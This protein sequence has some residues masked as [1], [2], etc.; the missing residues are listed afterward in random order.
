MNY[1]QDRLDRR[2]L[3]LSVLQ[4]HRDDDTN[5]PSRSTHHDTGN[6]TTSVVDHTKYGQ[7]CMML[8]WNLHALYHYGRAWYEEP[9][10]CYKLGDYVQM[11]EMYGYPEIALLTIFLYRTLTTTIPSSKPKTSQNHNSTSKNNNDDDDDDDDN[12]NTIRTLLVPP[13]LLDDT[14]DIRSPPHVVD[15]GD[16]QIPI[17]G[18]TTTGNHYEL[19]SA[20]EMMGYHCGCQDRLCGQ[21]PTNHSSQIF[22]CWI[23]MP[24]TAMK[25]IIAQL[26]S[27]SQQT[28]VLQYQYQQ[29]DTHVLQQPSTSL[30]PPTSHEML[31]DWTDSL[32]T[33]MT[34]FVAASKRRIPTL[35]QFWDSDVMSTS[36]QNAAAI[37]T[38]PQYRTLV[39][40]VQ[41]LCI[42]L[43]YLV[44][45][46]LAME[47]T[48]HL[49]Y[50][51]QQLQ[52]FVNQDM[53]EQIR[54]TKKEWD[55]LSIQYKSH[56]AYYVFIEALV[57]GERIKVAR[58]RQMVYQHIALWDR[59]W[60]MNPIRI[61]EN[62]STT[63]VDPNK[64]DDNA[65]TTQIDSTSA[66]TNKENHID[67]VNDFIYKLQSLVDEIYINDFHNYDRSETQTCLPSPV[68]LP[69]ILEYPRSSLPS[70][71]RAL[72]VIGDSHVLSLAWQSID[73]PISRRDTDTEPRLI[74]PIVITGLKAWHIRS[75]TR[76]FTNTCLHTMLCRIPPD[77]QTIIVSAGEIDCR[78]GMGGP[79][80]QGYTQE[81]YEHVKATVATYI[82][83]LAQIVQLPSNSISQ[84]LI[85]P[86]AP[87]I[88]R[89]KGRVVGQA[90][91]RET[92][93]VWN[94]ELRRQLVQHHKTMYLL[95]YIHQ[96]QIPIKKSN[97]DGHRTT[98][99]E[100]QANDV[101]AL[102]PIFNADSTHMN[103]AFA[104]IVQEAIIRC[105]CDLSKL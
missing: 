68:H 40:V 62:N 29:N 10:N 47:A 89:N 34:T 37:T 82:S 102:N 18:T 8:G 105:P 16:S 79:L 6:H 53:E 9:T 83:S 60:G 55:T 54:T 67:V 46:S 77:V 3:L 19:L 31:G 58:R 50:Q 2:E 74:V 17:S 24:H 57:L 56:W 85:T 14:N 103:G 90:S 80:L 27:Y 49:R 75:E 20:D 25:D 76:F 81:C 69:P 98:R 48:I 59:L 42:K 96:I 99:T 71:H 97:D 87:H 101:Y 35:F 64:S 86:V 36:S 43:L 94:D 100:S 23:P 7:I 65:S 33:H 11:I 51:Q 13:P 72:Y 22:P 26:Q 73:I 30:L 1:A 70:Q 78:E 38:M 5:D 93:R 61:V 91:R 95:D 39:P 28:M 45:P 44:V 32:P 104:P 12:N 84:I 52:R 4:K 41:L 21:S 92:I 63:K 66:P 15:S 88:E